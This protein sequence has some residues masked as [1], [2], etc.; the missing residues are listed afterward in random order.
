M[1]EKNLEK[2]SFETS[3][4]D[5]VISETDVLYVT[6]VQT[7][8]GSDH[9]YSLSSEK[10]N[11]LPKKSIVMH[12]L[13]RVSEIPREFDDDPRAKYFDQ[14]RYGLGCRMALLK[15]IIS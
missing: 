3:K 9:K 5:D 15:D 4:I 2:N 13:P 6:R 11:L 10:L 14:M 7:E 1:P 12:P 8:R